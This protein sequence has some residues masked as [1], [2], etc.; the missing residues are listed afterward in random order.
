MKMQLKNSTQKI[1]YSSSCND[2]Q[3]VNCFVLQNI[4]E[5]YC[6]EFYIK[7]CGHGDYQITCWEYHGNVEFTHSQPVNK[8]INLFGTTIIYDKRNT[9]IYDG[10]KYRYQLKHNWSNEP[11][12]NIYNQNIKPHKIIFE[13]I[14]NTNHLESDIKYFII[15]NDGNCVQIIF[16]VCNKNYFV[17]L[18]TS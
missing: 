3:F 7:L 16:Q 5:M 1:I 14:F 17:E 9:I 4:H 15:N 6:N 18:I 2:K 10:N 8:F 12:K 11:L 13:K